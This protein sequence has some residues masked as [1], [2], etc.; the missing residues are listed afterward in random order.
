MILFLILLMNS[1]FTPFFYNKTAAQ[2]VQMWSARPFSFF[3]QIFNKTVIQH[4][5]KDVNNT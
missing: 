1:L 5:E 2:M 4:A 3:N